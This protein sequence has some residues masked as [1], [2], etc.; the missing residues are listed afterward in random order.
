VVFRTFLLAA[1]LA[2]GASL[3]VQAQDA[4]TDPQSAGAAEPPREALEPSVLE[5]EPPEGEEEEPITEVVVTG[6][7]LRGS[8]VGDIEPEVTLNAA[9]IQALGAGTLAELLEALEPQ[10]RSGRGDGPPV[11]LLNGRRISGFREI[12]RLPPEAIERVEVLPEEV[13]LKYGYRADQRVVNFV[14][15]ERFRAT[16]AELDA[17]A[18]TAGGRADGEA[19]LGYLRINRSGRLSLDVEHRRAGALLESEREVLREPGRS[20]F[21]LLGNIG[22][23]TPGGEIDPALSA[24]VGA[25]VTVAGVP[26]TAAA[27]A[28]SLE[29]FAPG[30]GTASRTDLAPFRTLLPETESTEINGTVNRTLAGDVAGTLNAAWA[31]TQSRSLFGLPST[32]L[33]LPAG[34]PFSPFGSDV[35][36]Y[37]YLDAFGP[38]GRETETGTGRLGLV[39]DGFV[40]DFRWSLTGNLE[41][42]ETVNV[43]DAGVDAAALQARTAAGDPGLNPFGSLAEAARREPDRA[44]SVNTTANAELVV[45]GTLRDLPAGDLSATVQLQA[46]SRRFESETLRRGVSSGAELA[47]DR[48]AAQINLDIPVADRDREVLPALGELSLNAN[49]AIDQL[50]DFGALTTLGYGL[51]WSPVERLS[52]LASVTQEEGAPGVQQLG[53]P[54]LQTPNT[55]VFDFTRGETVE[56]TRIDGGNAALSANNRR[57][58][59]LEAN[60]RPYAERDLSLNATYTDTRVEDPIASF[61][62][63]T[64]EIEAAFPERF[65]RDADGRLVSLDVRPVNFARTERRELRY[66]LNY[67]RALTPEAG[68]GEGARGQ[69]RAGPQGGPRAGGGGFRRG[70]FGGRGAREGRLRLSVYHTW[71][72]ADTILI[73]EG[74]PELD[75][76]NGAA[77]GSRGGRPEH[78]I[79]VQ[80]GL[81]KSGFGGFLNGRWQ[82]G[83]VVRGGA[84]GQDGEA[85]DLLFSDQ[86]T[87]NLRL[88][89]DLGQQRRLVL[90]RPWLRGVRA[91]VAIDNIFDTRLDVRD[92]A[93][94]VPISF[95]PDLLDPLG[96]TVRF[97]VRKLFAP[98][99]AAARRLRGGGS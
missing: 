6:A 86:A 53:D 97:S 82:S 67:S 52:L 15:R 63:V 99:P 22:A 98:P 59:K 79:D 49:L 58:L 16:T 17:G 55:P 54:V 39:L 42:A 94:A 43:T 4:A 32:A 65:T 69:R 76:L 9:D 12:A 29:A 91:S 14:L 11:T 13:A 26:T 77:F 27:G 34:S 87:A 50:S 5:E 60:L 73:R 18:P 40:R 84:G 33:T 19:E 20:P 80:L 78:E 90:Q 23:A 37:R 71:R 25:P 45:N 93:G 21:D 47:R 8:V 88:F 51:N 66:G 81:F 95:Q 3:P 72:L 24:L 7:R 30:A 61:P 92:E 64:A 96:R 38:L 31:Q 75:L 46:E 10:T 41:R 56:V 2:N 74:L 48:A 83:T 44:E 35:V 89:V 85:S 28:P 1:L 57:V 62:A 36:L 70:G 68:G